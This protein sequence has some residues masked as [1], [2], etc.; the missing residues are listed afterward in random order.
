MARFAVH[1]IFELASLDN[2]ILV[3]VIAEG[4]IRTGMKLQYTNKEDFVEMEIS[5]VEFLDYPSDKRY[6]IGLRLSL[7]K[8]RELGL[9]R[10]QCWVGNEYECL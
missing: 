4:T 9:N 6:E 3:G 1:G 5:G 7:Q 10:P 2:F 8:T